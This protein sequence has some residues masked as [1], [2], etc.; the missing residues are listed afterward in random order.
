MVM[1]WVEVFAEVQDEEG[2]G[3]GEDPAIAE[4][5][6]GQKEADCRGH[7]GNDVLLFVGVH[8][9][10]DEEPD[11]IEDERAGE[12]GADDDGGLEIKVERVGGVG[13]GHLETD[14]E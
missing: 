5:C 9:G 6:S 12:D 11:L 4:P 1:M 7:K 2:H 3:S 8:A 10:R 14:V 13:H